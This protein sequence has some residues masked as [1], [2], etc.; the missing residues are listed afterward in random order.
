M[1]RTAH[2]T[3]LDAALS[4]L[5]IKV[6]STDPTLVPVP[7]EALAAPR[8]AAAPLPPAPS[9][10]GLKVIVQTGREEEAARWIV[11]AGGAVLPGGS[12]VLLA[13]LPPAA[14]PRLE[15]CPGIR[16]AEAPRQLLPRLDQARGPATGLDAALATLP[17]TGAGVVVGVVDSGVD[18]RHQ[19][20]RNADGSTRLEFFGHAQMPQGQQVSVFAEFDAKL[21]DAAL[22]GQGQVPQ[23]DPQ[24]HGTHCAS[25]AAG[26]GRAS[27]GQFRGAAP[28]ATLMAVR[29][30]PLLDSHI[31]WGIRRMFELAGDRPA[32][33][34]L[35]L[36][37]HLG[38]HDGT[39]AIENVIARESGPGRIVVVAAGNEGGDGIHWRGQLVPGQD[40]VIPIRIAD[41]NLQYVDVWVPR[42]DQVDVVIETPDGVQRAP[43]GT[44]VDTVFGVFEAHWQ[45]DPINRDQNLTLLIAAGRANHTWHIR[46]RPNVVVHGGVHAWGGTVNPS[47]SAHLFPGVTDSGF[48]LGM[49]ASEE[50]CLAVGSFV[51]RTQFPTGAGDFVATGLAAGQLSPFSSFGPTRYGSLKPDIAAP[52]QY[53]TAALAA[54]SEMATDPRYVPRHHPSGSYITIQGT[55]MATPFVAGVV[56]LLLQREPRLTPEDLQQRLRITAR[57]DGQTGPVWDAGFGFGKLDVQAL[58]AYTG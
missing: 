29:S 42:G 13:E 26:N 57:R 21:I 31:I 45:E 19:D 2:R 25:I 11:D 24:G 52:G 5:A 10:V 58:L 30:E 51:S 39:S 9:R 36:G 37:G 48:S 3:V 54:G 35:S 27:G 41:P 46:F 32:V 50:R 56:A 43:D 4:S 28:Q 6:A 16:R 47:T 55:S 33:V 7:L 12:Q 34:S 53:I 44:P 17:L 40:L 1:T 23:G 15:S 22:N 20:F 8:R 18:W 14:L 38:P 49:P